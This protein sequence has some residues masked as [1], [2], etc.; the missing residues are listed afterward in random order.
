MVG[1]LWEIEVRASTPA[2]TSWR[3][4]LLQIGP[5]GDGQR[6]TGKG[7]RATNHRLTTVSPHFTEYAGERLSNIQRD[8]GSWR[9]LYTVD[10]HVHTFLRTHKHMYR[11]RVGKSIA[12]YV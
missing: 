1:C 8:S 6:A 4:V 10:M 2:L 7:E 12:I 9:A 5:T 3:R 11:R